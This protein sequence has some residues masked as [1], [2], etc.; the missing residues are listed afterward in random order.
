[1]LI[2]KKLLWVVYSMEAPTNGERKSLTPPTRL[3]ITAVSGCGGAGDVLHFADVAFE[4]FAAVFG[5]AADGQ[6]VLAFEGLGDDDV[7]GFFELGEVAGEI[8]LSEATF[9]LEVEEAGFGDGAEHG[10]DHEA[11]GRMN[12]AVETGEG[13][14]VRCHFT[15]TL[16][17]GL[18]RR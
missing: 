5:E 6:G 1:V 2:L 17:T 12:H 9:A 7:A 4:G 15:G 18:R 10:H 8:A 14:Q 3:T 16:A 11:R 13:L